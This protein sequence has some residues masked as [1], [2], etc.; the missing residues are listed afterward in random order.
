MFVDLFF[1][2]DFL[3]KWLEKEWRMGLK[4][5]KLSVKEFVWKMV[6]MRVFKFVDELDNDF[7]CLF[8][9]GIMVMLL[10]NGLV[11]VFF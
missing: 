8:V 1:V 6:F 2:L 5:S 10:I 3:E 9:S 4:Y 11:E 7:V